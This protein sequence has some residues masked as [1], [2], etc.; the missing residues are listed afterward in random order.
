[1]VSKEEAIT[2]KVWVRSANRFVDATYT[3]GRV[4]DVGGVRVVVFPISVMAEAVGRDRETLVKWEK[5][6]RWPSTRWKVP[7]KR[8]KRWYSKEQI[9][10]AHRIHWKLCGGDY[11]V[12]H[13][14]HFNFFEFF[15]LVRQ[16]WFT[17]DAIPTKGTQV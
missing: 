1:M 7:D 2:F 15:K 13:S 6:K 9:L 11:G 14:R 8:T 4:F 10:A 3:T 17:V 5:E 12:S 16:C